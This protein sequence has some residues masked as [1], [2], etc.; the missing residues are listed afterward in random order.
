ML[1]CSYSITAGAL[2]SPFSTSVKAICMLRR[3]HSNLDE[4]TAG[5]P[6][7]LLKWTHKSSRTLAAAL[8]R[9]GHEVSHTTVTHLLHELGYSLR[10]NVKALEGEQHPDRDA[11]F[12]Y[13]HE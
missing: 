2:C 5:D 1:L 6:M 9:Q 3:K 12:R 11:Q 7:S 4:N 13:L 8:Q 10:R